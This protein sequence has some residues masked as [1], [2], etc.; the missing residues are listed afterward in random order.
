[1]GIWSE[2]RKGI[3]S[4]FVLRRPGCKFWFCCVGNLVW[5]G[6]CV[7]HRLKQGIFSL[8][9]LSPCLLTL[10][11]LGWGLNGH[12]S[13]LQT[14]LDFLRCLSMRPNKL[15]GRLWSSYFAAPH[16]A[17]PRVRSK[18][19]W[20]N[21][22]GVWS[23]PGIQ[24]V[25]FWYHFCNGLALNIAVQWLVLLLHIREVLGSHFGPVDPNWDL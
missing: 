3:F 15:G 11:S 6:R 21:T 9:R 4:C 14:A 22:Q 5:A 7:T 1:M 19:L 17:S 10:L 8:D 16:P 2:L 13:V 12:S 23:F 20:I 18:Y 25:L 24:S